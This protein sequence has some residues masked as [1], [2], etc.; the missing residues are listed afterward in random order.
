[1]I[2]ALLVSDHQGT[3]E[4]IFGIRFREWGKLAGPVAVGIFLCWVNA[5]LV[6]GLSAGV[7]EA[8]TGEAAE[9]QESVKM[10]MRM[11]S[12][13]QI[14]LFGV[15][16]VVLAPVVEELFFRG[17][18]FTAVTQFK[19]RAVGLWSTSIFFGVIHANWFSLLPLTLMGVLLALLYERTRNLLAP[20]AVHAAFNLINFVL[21]LMGAGE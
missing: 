14:G 12:G 13:W 15:I 7:I 21:V 17:V 2:L 6:G 8:I 3:W 9:L 1:M 4:A 18:L 10:V 5:Q 19:G 11:T 16:T 20:I